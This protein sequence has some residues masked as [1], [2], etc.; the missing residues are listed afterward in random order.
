[1]P[2]KKYLRQNIAKKVLIAFFFFSFAM[3]TISTA[4]VLYSQYNNEKEQ[5]LKDS[6]NVLTNQID[7]ISQVLWNLDKPLARIILNSLT[8]TQSFTYITIRDDQGNLFASSGGKQT[9]YSTF[10]QIPLIHTINNK[11]K[12]ETIGFIKAYITTAAAKEHIKDSFLSIVFVQILKSFITSFVFLLLM[13]QILIRHILTINKYIVDNAG[14]Q[15]LFKNKLKLDRAYTDDEL[16]RLVN[17]INASRKKHNKNIKASTK[18]NRHLTK[19]VKKRR[20]AEKKALSSHQQLLYVLNS[21]TKSVFSCNA[22]GEVLF[23]NHMALKLLSHHHTVST[24]TNKKLYFNDI[25]SFCKDDNADSKPIDL[26]GFAEKNNHISKLDAYFVPVNGEEKLTPVHITLIP[27][28]YEKT[29]LESGFI[30]VVSDESKRAKYREMS[31]MA[32]HDY[33]TKIYN[34]SYITEQ[35]N[36]IIKSEKKGYCFA[37]IDLDRFKN[38]NDTCGHRAGD[39]LL[40]LVAKTIPDSLGNNDTFARIGGDEFAILFD[41]MPDES[42]RKSQNI[43]A[44]IESLKFT[45]DNQVLNISCSI[46]VTA[47][48][49]SDRKLETIMSHADKACYQVKRSGKGAVKLY[50][51]THNNIS[52]LHRL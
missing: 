5:I 36:S 49:K 37:I 46:G 2:I 10:I 21:L 15:H 32:S 13:Y 9:T 12:G 17:T 7:S 34:R 42:L 30:I 25:I 45:Y 48:R 26:I 24:T 22:D 44:D 41:S 14:T 38:V 16:Q 33:L 28:H 43:I 4:F 47:I 40:K 20:K 18:E 52:T 6:Q 3:T 27:T 23:M 19:E 29:I 51:D 11:G 31:Y 39:E 35:I 8:H 1:M 50:T